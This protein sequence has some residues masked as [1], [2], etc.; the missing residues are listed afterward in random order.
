MNSIVAL[1]AA[2]Q[3]KFDSLSPSQKL[4]HNYMQRRS[5]ARGMGSDTTAYEV[6]CANIDKLMP[7]ESTL[8]DLQIGLILAGEKPE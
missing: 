5:F 7:H 3:A 8:T 2:A 1:I 4:R 6:H